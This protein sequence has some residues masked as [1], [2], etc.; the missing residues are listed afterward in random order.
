MDWNLYL[1]FLGAMLAIINPI[2]IW[3]IWSELTE[4]VQVRKVRGNIALLI[5]FSSMLILLVF[6]F[7]GRYLLE[8]FSIDLSVFRIAGGILLL[9]T[10]I[11]MVEGTATKLTERDERGGSEMD[12]AKMRFKKIV[13]PLLVPALAGPGSITTVILFG[14]YASTWQDYLA[15]SV[16][17]V[18]T[19]LM[20]LIIFMNSYFLEKKVDQVVFSVFTKVFGIIVAAIALQFIVEG[21]GQVFPGWLE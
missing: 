3:T 9:L 11:S 8:F 13:V 17:I 6:F 4:D 1:N 18:L 5:V 16:I 14:I 2:G 20:L 21:L 10:G 12:M 19:I 15:L 7:S